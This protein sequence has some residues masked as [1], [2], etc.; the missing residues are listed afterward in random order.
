MVYEKEKKI[1]NIYSY[2]FLFILFHFIRAN[3]IDYRNNYN[4]QKITNP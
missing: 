1:I 2:K 4:K 3:D